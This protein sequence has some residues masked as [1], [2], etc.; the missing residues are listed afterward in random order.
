V[1][2]TIDHLQQCLHDLQTKYKPPTQINSQSTNFGDDVVESSDENI[3]ISDTPRGKDKNCCFLNKNS[4]S[5]I[6][7]HLVV[8]FKVNLE[9]CHISIT[10]RA[11][12][13]VL[14]DIPRPHF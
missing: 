5:F 4:N 10:R 7:R 14:S 2:K 12:V 11:V 8:F 3:C 9:K 6:V 1:T 13:P